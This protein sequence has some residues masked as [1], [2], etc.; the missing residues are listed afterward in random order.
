MR[1]FFKHLFNKGDICVTM[2]AFIISNLSKANIYKVDISMLCARFDK[3]KSEILDYL[4]HGAGFSGKF[5]FDVRPYPNGIVSIS[6]K[7][8]QP[9]QLTIHEQQQEAD[10]LEIMD[11][12]NKVVKSFGKR[13]YKRDG[14]ETTKVI[15]KKLKE[16]AIVAEFKDVIDAKTY[17]LT[18]PQNHK[19]FRP[20]TLFGKK[21]ESYLNERTKP[22][23]KTKTDQRNE[24]FTDAAVRAA[25]D[26]Y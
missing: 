1:T 12:F 2:W 4:M 16:G 8:P 9:K 7:K 24:Q 19:W 18:D 11:Y 5:S 3:P 21:F 6:L 22:V 26:N 23:E 17:W 15:A 25:N 14:K 10:I 20:Q 13:G